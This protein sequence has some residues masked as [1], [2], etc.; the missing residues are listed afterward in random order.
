VDPELTDGD[1][2]HLQLIEEIDSKRVAL[3]IDPN[4]AMAWLMGG[5]SSSW[6]RPFEKGM[7]FNYI[8]W[9]ILLPGVLAL[10]LLPLI[11]ALILLAGFSVLSWLV[12][13]I[14]SK[15]LQ[16]GVREFI[17][18]DL[19][20]LNEL[21]EKGAIG[22]K[23]KSPQKQPSV[24]YPRPWVEVLAGAQSPGDGG[25]DSAGDGE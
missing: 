22:F 1:P 3:L 14:K 19:D 21:Y 12:A 15:V 8:Q 16:S 2:L 6:R 7:A 24:R 20:S 11:P 25:G 10:F 23:R 18:Q 17:R 9:L 13:R 4:R 5:S